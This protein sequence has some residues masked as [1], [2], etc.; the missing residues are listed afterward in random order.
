MPAMQHAA[1]LCLPLAAA[2]FLGA[3]HVA[4][5]TESA[6]GVAQASAFKRDTPEWHGEKFA[7]NR[8]SDCHA[9]ARWEDS[10]NPDAPPFERIANTPGLTRESL[11]KWLRDAHNYPDAMYFEIPAE[12][13]D[14]LAAYMITLRRDDYKPEI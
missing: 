9:V 5:E 10:R 8:C 12:H 14:D 1:S 11:G 7:R 6:Q 3:C 4:G 13:I 2:A